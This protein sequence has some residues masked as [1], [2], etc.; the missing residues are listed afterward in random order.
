MMRVIAGNAAVVRWVEDV[1]R[2]GVVPKLRHYKLL[3]IQSQI[4]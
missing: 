4:I 2:C 1:M 3:T